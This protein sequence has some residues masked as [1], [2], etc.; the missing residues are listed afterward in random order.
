MTQHDTSSLLITI[1]E[2]ANLL[3]YHRRTIHTMIKDGKLKTVGRRKGRRIV[4]SSLD[5]WVKQ[6]SQ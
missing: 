3:C 5:R 1:A 6:Q 2:A 4:R